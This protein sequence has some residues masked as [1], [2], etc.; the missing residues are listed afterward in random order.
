M[1]KD[2]IET[3]SIQIIET[4]LPYEDF[5]IYS[6]SVNNFLRSSIAGNATF[7]IYAMLAFLIVGGIFAHRMNIPVQIKD[8]G[9]FVEQKIKLTGEIQNIRKIKSGQTIE[10]N[11]FKTPNHKEE[12]ITGLL[13]NVRYAADEQWMIEAELDGVIIPKHDVPFEY[14]V[15]IG[16][17]S[18][19]SLFADKTLK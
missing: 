10:I 6:W 15:I 2:K 18:L 9:R 5:E 7:Y 14:S 1:H 12:R 17:Q 11:Y 3:D 4:S 16:R 13:K 19:L 8:S